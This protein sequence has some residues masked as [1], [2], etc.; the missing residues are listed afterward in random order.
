MHCYIKRIFHLYIMLHVQNPHYSILQ[1]FTSLWTHQ[2]S[3]LS[4]ATAFIKD[5]IGKWRYDCF[6][7]IYH[8]SLKS[9]DL[10]LENQLSLF[11]YFLLICQISM[12]SKIAKFSTIVCKCE[13]DLLFCKCDLLSTSVIYKCECVSIMQEWV[14]IY[15]FVQYELV[16]VL[17]LCNLIL[18]CVIYFAETYIRWPMLVRKLY[19]AYILHDNLEII[20]IT[21]DW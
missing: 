11:L 13:C 2:I 16:L 14:R 4:D 7:F 12:G 3:C 17:T 21:L 19:L 18:C 5:L 20:D 6:S 10:Y 15:F 9:M 8:S 1:S